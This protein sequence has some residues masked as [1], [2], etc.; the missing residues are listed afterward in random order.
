MFISAMNKVYLK[1]FKH[2]MA[3]KQFLNM[4]RIMKKTHTRVST[5]HGRI[6]SIY[7][8]LKFYVF[9]AN[10][11]IKKLKNKKQEIKF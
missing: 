1:K 5:S 11:L 7:L 2:L 8:D 3:S 10:S 9:I 6:I 4:E